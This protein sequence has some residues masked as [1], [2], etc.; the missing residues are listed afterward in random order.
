MVSWPGAVGA[1]PSD[2]AFEGDVCSGRGISEEETLPSAVGSKRAETA[3]K[4]SC[5]QHRTGSAELKTASVVSLSQRSLGECKAAHLERSDGECS[6][7]VEK[8]QFQKREAVWIGSGVGER[9]LEG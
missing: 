3:R 6:A 5:R 9:V 7:R 4:L 8:V 2:A 1:L